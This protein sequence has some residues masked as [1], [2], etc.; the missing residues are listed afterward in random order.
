[1]ISNRV[2]MLQAI[3]ELA[4]ALTLSSAE[5]VLN[6][7]HQLGHGTREKSLVGKQ[8]RTFRTFRTQSAVDVRNTGR[9]ARGSR[10]A[11]MKEGS[12]QAIVG[13]SKNDVLDVRNVPNPNINAYNGNDI[14]AQDHQQFLDI[15]SEHVRKSGNLSE[16]PG[17]VPPA[18]WYAFLNDLESIEKS[19]LADR[20]RALGW[21]DTDLYGCDPDRPYA[22]I[23]RAGLVWLLNGGRVV[24]LKTDAAAIETSTGARLV[25][26]RRKL[27][28]GNQASRNSVNGAR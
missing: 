17:D 28:G 27:C 23:D 24:A 22:R 6:V 14:N 2:P 15:I 16:P 7:G 5:N 3:D 11:S 9:E 12:S 1:M 10:P 19:G 20:A 21:S 25:Y 8:A 4:E 26:R 13:S 18:R